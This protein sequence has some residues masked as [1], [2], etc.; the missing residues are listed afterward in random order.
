MALR[1][2]GVLV[3]GQYRLVRQVGHGGMAAVWEARDEFLDRTVAVKELAISADRAGAEREALVR[4]S[5]REAR[6]AARLDHPNVI[7]VH[8]IVEFDGSPW[9]VM[10]YIQGGSLADMIASR[11]P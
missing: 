11:G 10:E 2:A 1:G 8:N 3:A 9:I 7:T 5:I 6:S 4:R